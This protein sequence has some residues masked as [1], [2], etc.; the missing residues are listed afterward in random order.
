[1]TCMCRP[2]LF[3]C[4]PGLLFLEGLTLQPLICFLPI[5]RITLVLVLQFAQDVAF[6]EDQPFEPIV[7]DSLDQK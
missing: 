1:M 6:H 5:L 7:Q 2:L 3:L 4:L